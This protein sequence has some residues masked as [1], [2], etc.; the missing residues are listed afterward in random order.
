MANR[1]LSQ[2]QAEEA[3]AA[4][5]KYGTKTEAAKALG[6]P[7][8]TLKSRI[9]EANN[10]GLAVKEPAIEFPV[11]PDDD[12]PVDQLIDHM[13]KRFT[14]RQKSHQAHTWFTVK[15]KDPKPIGVLWI[16]D[17]HLDDNGCNWPQLKADIEIC[18]NTPGM[19]AGNIGDTTN[20]W[21]GRL[22]HLYAKQDSSLK[23][24]QKLAAWFM[25]DG[26]PWLVWLIGNHDAWGDGA[27]VLAQMAKRFG[28]QKIV[29]H[30]W[31]ARFVLEFPKGQ[32]FRVHA[33]HN[34]KGHS[35]WNPLHG[36]LKQSMLGAEAHLFVC[37]DKH[38]WG[39]F[40]Y[41]NAERGLTQTLLRVRGYKFLNDHTRHLGIT[42]QQSGCSILTI[43]DPARPGV[44][45][46]HED[47]EQGAEYLTWLRNR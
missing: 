4:F 12:I 21:A 22:V 10:R 24:A 5:N 32:Q 29:C 14:L 15:V 9:D 34:M 37:G 20:N 47:I 33:A 40:R 31:E 7:V 1:P 3:I 2:E 38:N 13:S 18:K 25:L 16:G 36:P 35:M 46:A 30:D 11:F 43:F 39:V 44:V 45:Q 19:F 27:G 6:I 42:E 23:T 8:T 41:E 26:P 17:P 28:T